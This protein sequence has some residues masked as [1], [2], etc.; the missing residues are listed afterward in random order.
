MANRAD[1]FN[2]TGSVALNGATPSDGGS[3]WAHDPGDDSRTGTDGVTGET[4]AFSGGGG[5]TVSAWLDCGA[6]DHEADAEIITAAASQNGVH[7]RLTDKDNYYYFF[8]LNDGSCQLY[9]D[10]ANSFTFLGNGSG[11]YTFAVGNHLQLRVVGTALTGKIG[12]T[13]SISTTDSSLA[14]GTKA[15]IRSGFEGA[16]P[17]Y[18]SFAITDL[19]AGGGGLSIPVAMAHYRQQGLAA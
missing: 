18:N 7:A 9:K 16:K 6:A 15:G 8:A 14:A 3:A 4:V 19:A 17:Y 5:S 11:T 1:D 10:V 13:T 12:G 2:R